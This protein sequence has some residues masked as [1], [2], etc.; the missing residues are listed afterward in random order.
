M[1][2]SRLPRE[3]EVADG[4]GVGA[5]PVRLQ[6]GDDLH[7][8]DLGRAGDGARREAGAQGVEAGQA[9]AQAAGHVRDE[10]HDVRV[11]LHV[12]ELADLARVPGSLTRPMSLRPRSRSMMCSARSF[13]S[14]RSSASSA[15]VLRRVAPR[16][17]VPAMGCVVTAPSSTR[18]SI[19]GEEPTMWAVAEAQV[20]HVGRGVDGAQRAVDLERAGARRARRG[21]ARGRPG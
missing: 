21:A 20:V 18:T 10:V 3:V 1:A 5:A 6:L 8:P 19:S 2:V 4:A 13:S 12:H 14:A 16:G 15:C 7:R 9:V 11:A 17:R